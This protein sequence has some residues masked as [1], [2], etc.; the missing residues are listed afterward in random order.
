MKTSE[1]H[2]TYLEYDAVIYEL[3]EQGLPVIQARVA[4]WPGVS[5][6]S[7]SE[8]MRRMT[9]IHT[10]WRPDRAVVVQLAA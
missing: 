6:P 9:D 7:V 5:R 1:Y 3:S 4:E 8:M 10:E 2:A